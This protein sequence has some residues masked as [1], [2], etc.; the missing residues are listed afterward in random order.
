MLKFTIL[1]KLLK[2]P[3]GKYSRKSF[4]II[5]SFI[6]TMLLAVLIVLCDIF[7]KYT[8]SDVSIGVFN[9]M[10]LF[11]TGLV[12]SAVVDKKIISKTGQ[13]TKNEVE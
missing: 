5:V 8:A 13:E 2:T 9:S 12:T 4:M 10:L 6:V 3:A 11:L 7:F 1:N